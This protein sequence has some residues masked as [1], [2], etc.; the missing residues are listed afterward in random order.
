MAFA[1]YVISVSYPALAGGTVSNCDQASL[2]AALTGG[3]NVTFACSGV[4][5]LTNTISIVT[6][7][8]LDGT[9]QSVETIRFGFSMS[10]ATS[11]S[12]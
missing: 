2:E 11:V 9:G 7:T 12:P 6:N 5:A 8:V 4:I 3:G 10:P 1:W